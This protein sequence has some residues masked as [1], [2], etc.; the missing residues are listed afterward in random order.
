MGPRPT[1]SAQVASDRDFGRD[2]LLQN[3]GDSIAFVSDT[4]GEWPFPTGCRDDLHDY[5][6]VTARLVDDLI[7]KKVLADHGMEY[8][9]EGEPETV[10]I[11]DLRNAW[12]PHKPS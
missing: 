4:C 8:V 3:A 12:W 6:D 10:Y 7:K 2:N 9:D 5:V 1:G 11:R